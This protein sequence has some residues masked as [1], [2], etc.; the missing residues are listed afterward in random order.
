MN[1]KSISF[2]AAVAIAVVS[3]ATLASAPAQAFDLYSKTLSFGGKAA[4]YKTTAAADPSNYFTL[5][6]FAQPG[7]TGTP[8]VSQTPTGVATLQGSDHIFGSEDQKI[9]LLDLTLSKSGSVYSLVGGTVVDFIT[10]LNNNIKFTLTGFNLAKNTMNGGFAAGIEGFFTAPP[11][12]ANVPIYPSN[13]FT[14]QTSLTHVTFKSGILDTTKNGSTYSAD[15]TSIPTP[16]LLP[17]LIGMGVAA[18]RKRKG[19]SVEQAEA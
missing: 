12:F 3:S 1:L 11:K 16:A 8:L 5:D 7:G 18:W 17:G 9:N 10:G 19:E 6:F 13:N 15:L 2:G 4:L 14:S